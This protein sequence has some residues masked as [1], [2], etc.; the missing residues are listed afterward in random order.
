MIENPFHRRVLRALAFEMLLIWQ[1]RKTW[2][3]RVEQNGCEARQLRS[4]KRWGVMVMMM[5]IEQGVGER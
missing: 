3:L 1:G 2:R 4:R 5:V